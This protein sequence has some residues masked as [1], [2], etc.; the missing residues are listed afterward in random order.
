MLWA[1]LRAEL[2]VKDDYLSPREGAKPEQ[3]GRSRRSAKTVP[4]Q[5]YR[6]DMGEV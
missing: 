4:N 5:R 1:R 6:E 2:S 3:A